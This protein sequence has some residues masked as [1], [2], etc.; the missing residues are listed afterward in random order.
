MARGS[1]NNENGAVYLRIAEGKIVETVDESTSGAVSRTT[2][3]S[4]EHPNGRTVWERKDDYVDGVITSI[5]RK[6]REYKGELMNSLAVRMADKGESYLLEI[7]EGSRYWSSF[8]L[9]LPNIDLSKSVRVSPYDF[10]DKEG[11][12][13]IGLNVLQN[14][15]KVEPKWNKTSPGD[16]PQGKQVRV[17]GKTVWD[18]EDRDQYLLNVMK[19]IAEKM[20]SADDAFEG[21]KAEVSVASGDDDGLPF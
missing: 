12:R 20:R 19:T 16:L 4:D 8:L 2:K 3:P 15:N 17:N 11:R 5:Y 1:N 10:T 7:K 6:E 13:V 9:R 18:F 21:S 14:G